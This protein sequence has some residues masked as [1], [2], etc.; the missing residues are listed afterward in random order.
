MALIINGEGRKKRRR[1]RSLWERK[2]SQCGSFR[3]F[4]EG[5]M[6]SVL[7]ESSELGFVR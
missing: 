5:W 1:L 4:T 6:G 3:L 7:E 2:L